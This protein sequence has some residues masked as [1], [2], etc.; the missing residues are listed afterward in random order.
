MSGFE[1]TTP[2][3]DICVSIIAGGD[4]GVGIGPLEVLGHFDLGLFLFKALVQRLDSTFFA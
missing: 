2:A 1:I 4:D 3:T